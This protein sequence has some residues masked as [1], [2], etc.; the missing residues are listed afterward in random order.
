MTNFDFK[1]FLSFQYKLCLKK[2]FCKI[3]YWPK[4]C[5]LGIIPF[6]NISKYPLKHFTL[7][8]P[9]FCI[10]EHETPQPV[11]RYWAA[12]LVNDHA[13]AKNFFF[14]DLANGGID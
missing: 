13:R 5:R 14:S 9:V 1:H 8:S 4:F 11:I 10:P 2:S 3:A 12:K 6:Q 7:R